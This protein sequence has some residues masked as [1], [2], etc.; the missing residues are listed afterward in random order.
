MGSRCET[1]P[2]R[3][4]L[5]SAL[6]PPPGGI[7][8]WTQTMLDRGLPAPFEFEVVD[9]RVFRRSQF[10][11]PKLSPAELKRNLG[12]L[13]RI[14]RALASGRF[15][16]M[17]LNCGLTL[18]GAPRNLLSALIAK[19]ANV[20]YVAHLRGTFE[21]PRGG[22][23]GA[24]FYRWAWRVILDGATCVLALGQPS[25]RSIME[26]GDFD[27]KTVA[28]FPN[29][30][31]AR[32]IPER[33]HTD[34]RDCLNVIFTGA[35]IEEKGIYTILEIASRVP[36]ARFRLLGGSSDEA[37][38]AKL[39]RLI[40]ERGLED[41][42]QVAGPFPNREVVRTLADSDAFLFPSSLK[43]EGFPI[44][45]AEAMAAGLPV[46]ASTV[47][48]LPEMVDVPDGGFLADAGDASA[49]V[50]ALERLR[51]D[52]ALRRRMGR[53]NRRK[54]LRGYDYD[55]VA[56]RLCAIWASTAAG[57]A[58]IGAGK[59]GSDDY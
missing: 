36:N 53:H 4:L 42:V 48:A 25:Y 14:R 49:H 28:L 10:T 31:D 1:L 59:E 9:T 12:I 39:L 44:S 37:S 40:R 30:V 20:P 8:S 41:R 47:G 15:D 26:L 11:P 27:R 21:I 50:A 18:S 22:G 43:H 24:R 52:P 5:V 34:R 32:A 2:T 46:V 13:W 3:A 56:R 29:F 23:I 16:L 6:P 7:A 54:A 51:C 58:N 45:V 55:V 35:L 33:V 17:H 38:H 19:R 57:C